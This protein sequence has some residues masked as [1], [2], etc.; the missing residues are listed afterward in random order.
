MKKEFRLYKPFPGGGE[1]ARGS[2]GQLL[3]AAWSTLGRPLSP[4]VRCVGFI[5]PSCTISPPGF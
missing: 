5:L 4:G 2:G 1:N 3:A